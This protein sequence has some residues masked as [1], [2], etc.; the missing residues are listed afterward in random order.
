MLE[1]LR[2]SGFG[3]SFVDSRGRGAARLHRVRIGPLTDSGEFDRVSRLLD[4]I[5]V[6]GALVMDP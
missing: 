2:S 6:D 4:A 1:R 3:N 5:G